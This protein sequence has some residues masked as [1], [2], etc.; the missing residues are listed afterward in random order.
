MIHDQQTKAGAL[1]VTLYRL[2]NDH[3]GTLR[4]IAAYYRARRFDPDDR[5]RRYA[6]CISDEAQRVMEQQGMARETEKVPA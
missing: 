2:A 5:V 1:E 6:R 4:S 3:P